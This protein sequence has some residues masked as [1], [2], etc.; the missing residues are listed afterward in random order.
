MLSRSGPDVNHHIRGAHRILIMFHDNHRIAQITQ[1]EQGAEQLVIV[2][3]VQSD[4]RLIQN[5]GNT[6]QSGADLCGKPDP[7]RLTA[8]QRRCTAGQRK[9]IQ[10]NVI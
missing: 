7:L 4:R 10:T 9:I 8:G 5:I 3:L 2:S 1:M 6:H